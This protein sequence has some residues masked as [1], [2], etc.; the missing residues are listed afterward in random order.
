M[1]EAGTGLRPADWQVTATTIDCGRVNDY[2][3]VIINGDWTYSCTWCRRYRLAE[4][5]A[6]AKQSREIKSKVS[7][8]PGPE[9]DL[10]LAYRDKLIAQ[11]SAVDK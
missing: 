2:V 5:G 8:C 11:E 1:A 10:V 7:R 4:P 3:T 6:A 9:C